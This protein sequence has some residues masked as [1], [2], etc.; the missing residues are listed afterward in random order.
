P[1]HNPAHRFLVHG[2]QMVL[3]YP[4]REMALDPA[5]RLPRA[6]GGP[7]PEDTAPLVAPRP[8]PRLAVAGRRL[9][10]Q[11]DLALVARHLDP[12]EAFVHPVDGERADLRLERRRGLVPASRRS[13]AIGHA[14]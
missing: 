5:D 12:L 2:P 3:R 11:G 4:R 1:R 14:K 8:R 7:P 10:Q 6:P 13:D 9:H